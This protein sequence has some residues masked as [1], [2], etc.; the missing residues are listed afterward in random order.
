MKPGRQAW[1]YACLPGSR[2]T[3]PLTAVLL[4]HAAVLPPLADGLER[5][6][7]RP[8]FTSLRE[9]GV[10]GPIGF[11][12]RFATRATRYRL[13]AGAHQGPKAW[14][15]I[16]VRAHARFR[17]GTRGTYLLSGSTNGRTAAQIKF[18]VTP[19]QILT[20]TLGLISG[21][22]RKV[23]RDRVV[24]TSLAN[25]LQRTGVKGGSNELRFVLEA[26]EGPAPRVIEVLPSSGLGVTPSPPEE[27]RLGVPDGPVV[28]EVDNE[29]EVPFRLERH[30]GRP[31]VPV[32]V[33]FQPRSQGLVP[34]GDTTLSF[35]SVGD[36]RSGS[37]SVI[38]VESGRFAVEFTVPR[39]YNEPRAS[40][41][42]LAGFR[43]RELNL[44]AVA[45]LGGSLLL[46]GAWF[47]TVRRRRARP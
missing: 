32:T 5:I 43:R 25:Y 40:A 4:V 28:G 16:K 15:T 46:A 19:R 7:Q 47:I 20:E 14:F 3:W 42:V 36:G 22:D 38:P 31:D 34:Q 17:Q 9:L 35:E 11:D 2:A 33:Q 8:G 12:R 26:I 18:T 13:P 24:D 21:R 6:A 44:T 10:E 27:L 45:I 1:Y 37:F 29:L 39:Q 23:T 30:G 41:T